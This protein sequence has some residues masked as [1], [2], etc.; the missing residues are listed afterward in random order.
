MPAIANYLV[1]LLL[2]AVLLLVFFVI[3]TR[4]TPYNEVL[5]IRQG[6]TA[7]ALSLSGAVIGF[8]LTIASCILH[9]STI[10]PFVAWASGALVVQL[11]TYLV[12]TRLMSMSKE[13]IE[14]NNVAFGGILGAVSL[15]VGAINA[16]C[17]S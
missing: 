5:L 9:T 6:N 1:F 17:I 11:L 15:S 4:I 10:I 2:A 13:H 14:S 8:S 7:A 16:A 3:Y 12:T